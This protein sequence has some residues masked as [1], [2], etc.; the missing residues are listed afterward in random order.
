M[1]PSAITQIWVQKTNEVLKHVAKFVTKIE[2]FFE[3]ETPRMA[4]KALLKTVCRI[5]A[6]PSE[7]SVKCYKF[8]CVDTDWVFAPKSF[9]TVYKLM[10]CV[11]IISMRI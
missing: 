7:C 9:F 10:P 3:V 2:A 8:Q 11:I 5:S 1:A 4:W 6:C